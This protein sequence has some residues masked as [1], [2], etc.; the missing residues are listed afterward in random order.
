MGHAGVGRCAALSAGDFIGK[1]SR[2]H[3]RFPEMPRPRI[4]LKS[5]IFLD[6]FCR[7]SGREC[8][9]TTAPD[10]LSS[11]SKAGRGDRYLHCCGRMTGAIQHGKSGEILICAGRVIA[12][13]DCYQECKSGAMNTNLVEKCQFD[14][15]DQVDATMMTTYVNYPW[16]RVVMALRVFLLYRSLGPFIAAKRLKEHYGGPWGPLINYLGSVGANVPVSPG[17]SD[18]EG[19]PLNLQPGEWVEVRSMEEILATLDERGK[20]RGMGFMPEMMQF[21]GEKFRVYKHVNTIVLESTGEQ[22]K[23]MSP[24]VFLEGVECDGSYHGRCDR[25]CYCFWREVWLK[26]VPGEDK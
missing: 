13:N 18:M 20:N 6:N 24:T 19:G 21:C 7:H 17:R 8:R 14:Y 22:R 3:H 26:R 12:T 25:S 23:I 10:V 15:R 2:D 9:V 1:F 11:A 16:E 4:Y 5:L